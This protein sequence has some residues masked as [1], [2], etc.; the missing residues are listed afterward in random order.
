MNFSHSLQVPL[1]T[2]VLIIEGWL[3]ECIRSHDWGLESL[4]PLPGLAV[5]SPRCRW[6]RGL[7]GT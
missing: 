7:A 1:I 5:S 2:D 3:D 6:G 4:Q